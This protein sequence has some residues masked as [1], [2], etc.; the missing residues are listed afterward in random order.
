MTPKISSQLEAAALRAGI[1]PASMQMTAAMAN[2]QAPAATKP[3]AQPPMMYQAPVATPQPT[4]A[5]APASATDP[6]LMHQA[7]AALTVTPPAS[8][9]ADAVQVAVMAER[10]RISDISAL[11]TPAQ[12][13]LATQLINAGMSLGDAAVALLQDR[14]RNPEAT[15]AQT[16][17]PEAQTTAQ[18]TAAL[19]AQLRNVPPVPATSEE[20]PSMMAQ[21]A[22]LTDPHERQ[23]FL[24]A[25]QTEIMAERQRK[26][27]S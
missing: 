17:T 4:A 16:P 25:H 19:A 11:A 24:A 14:N 20:K 18:A 8:Q 3:M 22:A 23:A 2:P 5:A 13:Q 1:D 26:A 27:R 7:P 6:A 15:A 12:A 21:Y 9:P 10:K